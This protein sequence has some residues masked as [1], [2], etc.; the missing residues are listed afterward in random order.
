MH[1]T[2]LSIRL[3]GYD[4]SRNAMYSVTSC[5]HDRVCCIGEGNSGEF[6]ECV[7]ELQGGDE[8][9]FTCRYL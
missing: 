4:Y 5:V 1:R 3:Q 2:R 7:G 9:V 8:G 6:G